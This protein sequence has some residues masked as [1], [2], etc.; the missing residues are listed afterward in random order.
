MDH[1]K[2]CIYHKGCLDGQGAALAMYLKHPYTEF[3]PGVYSEAPPDVTN[4]EVYLV[5][6]SY[7]ID[8][9]AQML[10][11]A[12]SVTI[13]DH[14]RTAIEAL[15]SF[16]HPKLTK[17][18]SY[19]HSGAVLTFM[20][21]FPSDEVPQLLQHIQ[22]RDLWRFELTFTRPVTSYFYSLDFEPSEWAQY[23]EGSFWRRNCGIFIAGGE[24]LMRQEVKR[25]RQLCE[26]S[27]SMEICGHTVQVVNCN[28]FYASDVGHELAK[29]RPFGATYYDVE[30]GRVFSLR[31]D[32]KGLDVSEI[33][34]TFGGGGHKHAS[35]F[36]ISREELMIS[37][38]A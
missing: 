10:E 33:A 2:L 21:F 14:H 29:D 1:P 20:Y 12:K 3:Y 19:D 22:D 30:D 6:F 31:S 9:L 37:G 5:D 23:L 18:L 36:K 27:R 15:C 28:H 11:T 8:V 34:K 13:I 32:D 35:G 24:T 26:S 25:V 17:V 38:W 7:P 16:N 4:R